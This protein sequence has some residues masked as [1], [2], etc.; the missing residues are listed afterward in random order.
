MNKILNRG[1]YDYMGYIMT[2]FDHTIE[3]D[4]EET[5]KK[6]K[7]FGVYPAWNFRGIVWYEDGVFYC[8]IWQYGDHVNT[9]EGDDLSEIMETAS[10]LYGEA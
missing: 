5:L 7:V 1:A 6:N 4:A 9:I 2:N 8:E 3:P 10:Q